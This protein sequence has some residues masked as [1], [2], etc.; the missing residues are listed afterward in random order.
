M[1]IVVIITIGLVSGLIF[2]RL[3]NVK[4]TLENSHEQVR[5]QTVGTSSETTRRQALNQLT[6][7]TKAGAQLCD[8]VFLDFSFER[9][10][11]DEIY[12]LANAFQTMTVRMKNYIEE[13]KTITAEKERIGLS[14]M[15]RHRSRRICFRG[16]SRPSR[17]VRS[18]ISMPPWSPPRR[19]AVISMTSSSWTTTIWRS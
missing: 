6:A 3:S 17:S 9:K 4:A 11:N 2:Y 10:E 1:L 5:Q 19:W 8:D 7:S 15:S 18:S 13:V 12:V 14:L 16:S